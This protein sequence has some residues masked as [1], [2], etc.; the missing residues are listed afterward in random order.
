MLKADKL[1]VLLD[2]GNDQWTAYESK[3]TIPATEY[4]RPI[5]VLMQLSTV[6]VWLSGCC[7]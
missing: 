2:H 1:I 7:F 4:P 5:Q 6:F 3:L